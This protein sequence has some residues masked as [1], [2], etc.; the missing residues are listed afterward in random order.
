MSVTGI[1]VSP[2]NLIL[3]KMLSAISEKKA[4]AQRHSPLVW[5]SKSTDSRHPSCRFKG[6]FNNEI[7]R[8]FPTTRVTPSSNSHPKVFEPFGVE[9]SA[10][11]VDDPQLPIIVKEDIVRAQITVRENEWGK[12]RFVKRLAFVGRC[13]SVSATIFSADEL[14]LKVSR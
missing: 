14:L 12:N 2:T 7:D 9:S 10:V 1:Q 8:H 13:Y 11:P 5:T 6:W 4:Q 3:L